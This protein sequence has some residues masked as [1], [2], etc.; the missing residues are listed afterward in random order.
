MG[1]RIEEPGVIYVGICG[2]DYLVLDFCYVE[3]G[4]EGDAVEDSAEAGC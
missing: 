3:G 4:E 1:R 2:D